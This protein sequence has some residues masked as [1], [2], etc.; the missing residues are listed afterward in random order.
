MSVYQ[1]YFSPTGGTK[2]ISEIIS[3]PWQDTVHIDLTDAS[4]DNLA[5]SFN[6]DD[7]CIISVPAFE[8]R[9][10]KVN[11]RR[12]KN[13]KGSNTPCVLVAVFGNRRIN[14]T[15]LELKNELMKCG[16][17]PFAALE[18]VAQHSVMPQYG[19]GRPDADDIAELNG[20]AAKIKEKYDIGNFT[21]AVEVPGDF[22]YIIIKI[23]ALKPVTNEAACCRCMQCADK[24]PV[25]VID[26]SNPALYDNAACIACMRCIHICPTKAKYLCKE[27]VDSVIEKIGF[28]LEGRKENHLYL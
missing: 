5:M 11:L 7:L 17:M 10:P 15:L 22:P 3:S 9:V 27:D 13:L 18:A 6:S 20:F 8:G 21:E 2:R 28:R 1:I 16:F 25:G 14:D 24:C 19:T 4:A 12:L 23:K 26:S